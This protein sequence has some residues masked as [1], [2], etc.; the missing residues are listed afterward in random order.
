MHEER[1]LIEEALEL[2]IQVNR[3]LD[4]LKKSKDACVTIQLNG[5]TFTVSTRK[6]IR[7]GMA[8]I[9]DSEHHNLR[10]PK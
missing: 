7:F 5:T 6:D 2:L 10:N 8:V 3:R 9:S 4:G 1:Q